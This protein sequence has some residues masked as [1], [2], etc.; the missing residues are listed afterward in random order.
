M[1]AI[2]G[3]VYSVGCGGQSVARAGRAAIADIGPIG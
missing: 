1:D 3:Q 2:S